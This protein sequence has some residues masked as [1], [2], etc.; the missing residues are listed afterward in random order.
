MIRDIYKIMAM[1]LF[2]LF[3]LPS[4][5][6]DFTVSGVVKEQGTGETIPGATVLIK[7]TTNGSVTDIDG[8]YSIAIAGDGSETLSISFIGYLASEIP[9]NGRSVINVDLAIDIAELEEVVV[10]GY[11]TQKKKVV[12]GAISSVSS[13][14]ISSTPILRV[15]QALQ[16][17]TAGVQVTNLSGQPGEAPT[18]RIRGTG[19][20]GDSDPIYVVDGMVVGGIDYLN[21]GDI[22]SID[23]LKDAA[24]AAIYGA[25]AANGVVLI[26]TKSGVKGQ[27]N[28]TY[29]GYYGIQ[30]AANKIDMLNAEQYKMMQNEGAR[31]GK[32][33]EPFDLNQISEHDTNWQDHLFT[34]NA[35]MSNHE[36]QISGG[37][38]KSTF[39][40]SLSAFSQQGI[41][42]GEK[43]QFD[44][45]TA[46]FNSRHQVTDWFRFGN[47]VAYTR[48][49]TR[50]ISSN[51]SFSGAYS[52]ALNI[53]PLTPVTEQDADVLSEAPYS[54]Q[55]VIY[56]ENG[57]PYGISNYVS[58]EIVNPL[59]LIEN[60]NSEWKEDKLVGGV[61]AEIEPV[62][63][64]VFKTQYSIDLAYGINSSYTPLF[65]LNGSQGNL[66]RTNVSKEVQRWFNWQWDNTVTYSKKMGDHNF[67]VL[68][69]T[70]AQENLYENVGAS[71]DKVPILDPEHVYIDQA[72]DTTE[73]AWGGATEH[74]LYSYFGRLTYDFKD[75]Y[76]FTVIARRDGSS[77]F[78]AN[79][80]FG[81]FP[82][83]GVAWVASDEVF[84][85]NLGPVNLLKFRASWGVNGNE[86]I[87][88]F[89]Y[90]SPM[91]STRG[92]TFGGGN[93]VGLSPSYAANPEIQWEESV[94]LDLAV[95]F[96]LFQ[97]K[98]TGTVDVYNKTT[99][100]L[101]YDPS[102][103]PHAG[104]DAP[105]QN[106]GTVE[107]KGIE[108]SL[109]FRGASGDLNYSI[110]GN[111]TF[112][113]N[114]VISIDNTGNASITGASWSI[115]GPVTHTTEG[116]PIS[117][118]YGYKTDGIFQSTAEVFQ[119]IG[120][121]GT[122]LQSGAVPGDVRFV[123]INNDGL[124]DDSDRTKIGNPTPDWT[125]GFNGSLDYKGVDF[126]FLVTG[127]LGN[128]IFTGQQRR[129]L[130]YTNMPTDMLGRWTA[131]NPSNTI[132]RFTWTD[133]NN[134]NRVS[135]LY[136]EEGSYVRLKNI[137]VGYTLPSSILDKIGASTWRFYVSAENLLTLTNYSGADPEIGAISPFDIA[138]DRGV[139][140]QARTFRF[141]TSITF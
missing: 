52:S 29:S 92:Y 36:L 84:L 139:Y 116:E 14:E 65:Y 53:D 69:G 107:N 101:L 77:N 131:E 93:V 9:I 94:Q 68:L 140:P 37:S 66:E 41:I 61:F 88:S 13:K 110:G 80:K 22:E 21:P 124:I 46:R 62:K 43:S 141:G 5:G 48:K 126:S 72:T 4:Y 120:P 100:G 130:R 105:W 73:G 106:V 134:N 133:T 24:S 138:I 129:D 39:T 56:D 45:Y 63:G 79:A 35:P 57:F 119:H 115:A 76:S 117:Y 28:L 12:T 30:N 8:R 3:T 112:N 58:S 109:N 114:E 81:V 103:Q 113:K 49:I 122:P 17:R 123:D 111:A 104:I 34:D 74:A 32:L 6:Q 99:K 51:T 108:M 1:L 15:E 55:P 60:Q 25:R 125:I 2:C 38:E 137:Q 42:G 89:R 136:I 97:N 83:L 127:A 54:T 85:Q 7:G 47:N 31:N 64:L 10:I 128:D 67:S 90:A 98:L 86:S 70:S 44:R 102:I 121:E 40:S 82:S 75:K 95:D 96:G 91:N 87:P 27:M 71:N 19:T 26:T 18:V 50:D 11:G 16:G 33:D 118:F 20:T 59:A 135:D 132:P 78:G 23:V